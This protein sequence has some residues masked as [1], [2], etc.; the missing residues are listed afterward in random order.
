MTNDELPNDESQPALLVVDDEPYVRDVVARWLANEGYACEQAGDAREALEK[1]RGQEFALVITDIKMPGM[2]GIELIEKMKAEWP[3][4][5]AIVLT[6]VDD[7]AT[8]TQAM[9]LG[10]YG[11]MIKPFEEN[12]VL[13]NVAN[14]LRRRRLERMRD[15]YEEELEETV[16]KRTAEVRRT[17]EEVLHRLVAAAE[18]RDRETGAH[19]KRIGLYAATLAERLGWAS[20][21][22]R[23]LMLAAPMH[24]VGKIAVADAVLL[25]TGEFTPEEFEEMK[26][27]TIVGAQLLDGS[28]IALLR[29][30]RDIAL[31]HHE[32]WDGTGYP[33]GL[34]GEAI[35]E[36]ARIVAACDVYDALVNDRVY[37]PA[38]PED[39]A[40]AIME[41]G[42]GQHFDPEVL[43]QFMAALPDLR[44]IRQELADELRA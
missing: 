24:D 18:H 37:R 5:A 16:Q 25:K 3:G 9:D 27:H 4:T 13:I 39:Q 7:R 28:D 34:G 44:R 11:Y 20:R 6:G 32:K 21:P 30:A 40:L 41:E 22:A 35:P 14:A 17:Q 19:I 1:L 38:L 31:C 10:A 12:E 43:G 33:Q 36:S 26:K 23:D 8:A 2:S 42:R 15:R 29:M